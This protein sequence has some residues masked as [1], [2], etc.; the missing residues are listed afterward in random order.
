MKVEEVLLKV[1]TDKYWSLWDFEDNFDLKCVATDLFVDRRSHYEIST[2]VYMCDNGYVG[3]TGIV[4]C[5]CDTD[6]PVD[7]NNPCF[8]EEYVSVNTVSYVKLSKITNS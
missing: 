8:A 3:I 6:S 2:N 5:Y 4:R 7:F 1:N